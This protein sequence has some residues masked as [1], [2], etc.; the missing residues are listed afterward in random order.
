MKLVLLSVIAIC[1]M[2]NHAV[3]SPISDPLEISF[4]TDQALY[5]LDTTKSDIKTQGFWYAQGDYLSP[6][7][8]GH[9]TGLKGA[10]VGARCYLSD[11]SALDISLHGLGNFYQKM[12][13][14]KA[15]CLFYLNG[16][17][18]KASPYIGVGMLGGL[19]KTTIFIT[20]YSPNSKPRLV[21]ETVTEDVITFESLIGFE[22]RNDKGSTQFVQLAYIPR[23]HLQLSVGFGF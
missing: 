15:D 20:E 2:V 19:A 10:G 3:A 4:E 17:S 23:N 18:T 16:A 14:L 13:L 22:I 21:R 7:T 8:K 12:G 5:P 1:G 6:M 11:L 9:K